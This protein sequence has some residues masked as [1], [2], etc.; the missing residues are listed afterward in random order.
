MAKRK[1]SAAAVPENQMRLFDLLEGHIQEAPGEPAPGSF[2]MSAAVR[3]G[4]SESIRRSGMKRWEIAGQMSELLGHEITES[5]LNAWSAESR[6]DRRFPTEY[7]AAFCHVTGDRELLKQIA[8]RLQCWLY[9]SEEAVMAELGRINW[10]RQQLSTR[11]RQVKRYLATLRKKTDQ[12]LR[13][14]PCRR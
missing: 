8:R 9:E 13:G 3:Q 4:I 2:D 7:L 11:E 1:R 5:M 14:G 6:E 10:Q 12:P